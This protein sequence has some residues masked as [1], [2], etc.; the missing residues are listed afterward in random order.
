[1]ERVEYR[2]NEGRIGLSIKYPDEIRRKWSERDVTVCCGRCASES[3]A[4]DTSGDLLVLA[5]LD[6]VNWWAGPV[7]DVLTWY[8]TEEATIRLPETFER[9]SYRTDT[10]K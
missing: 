5:C 3:I 4:T 1:M 7:N 2:A 9:A 8:D 10:I 6:C